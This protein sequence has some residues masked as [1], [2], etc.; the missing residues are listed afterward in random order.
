MAFTVLVPDDGGVV[1]ATFVASLANVRLPLPLESLQTLLL[2][3][4]EADEVNVATRVVQAPTT[5]S[6]AI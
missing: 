6:V 5:T 3:V 1:C 2:S 4:E